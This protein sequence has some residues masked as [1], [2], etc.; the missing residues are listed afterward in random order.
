[1]KKPKLAV[2]PYRHDLK[3]KF[4]LDLRAFGRGR[5]FF[6]T[7]AEGEAECRRQLTALER[8]GRR[9]SVCHNVKSPILSGRARRSPSMARRSILCR[10]SVRHVQGAHFNSYRWR[11]HWY[12]LALCWCADRKHQSGVGAGRPL[13]ACRND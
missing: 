12:C 7:R 11:R 4:V 10:A 5:K 13:V 9:Q 3:Y 8:H 2:L 6:K 1:M